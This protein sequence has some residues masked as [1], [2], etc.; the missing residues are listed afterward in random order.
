MLGQPE[1]VSAPAS[2][3]MHVS[4]PADGS[5]FA[6]EVS[7]LRTT[8][9][10]IPFDPVAEVVRGDPVSITSGT[11]IWTD[12]DVSIDGRLALRSQRRQEDIYV[13]NADGTNITALAPDENVDRFPRWSP[14]GSRIAFSSTKG[15]EGYEIHS[16]R[17]D[18]SDL[19]RHTYYQPSAVHFPI[20]SP[21]GR[22]LAFTAYITAGGQT[23]AI[24][25]N[26]AWP[27]EPLKPLLTPPVPLDLRYRPWS[28]S[29][30]GRRI[31]AYSERGAGMIV[32]DV[33]TGANEGVSPV[34]AKPRWLSDSRRLVYTHDG[35]LH[36][37]DTRLMRSREISG[38][39]PARLSI[40]PCPATA[41]RSTASCTA[42]KEASGSPR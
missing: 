28:W 9:V 15:G 5:R 1:P 11:R 23:F 16:V 35:A 40:R 4:L 13:G 12:L 27:T 7:D 24:D 17:A 19:R 31:V 10:R 32:D 33:A 20:W 30:D 14:D 22:R 26:V 8:V 38:R 41:G 42:T 29:P 6:Y 21:D 2:A 18:G 39:P 25:P 34:G 36:L 37:L 3:V